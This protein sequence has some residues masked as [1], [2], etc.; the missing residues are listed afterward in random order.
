[1]KDCFIISKSLVSLSIPWSGVII[2]RESKDTFIWFRKNGSFETNR[3][4]DFTR[5]FGILGGFRGRYFE[6]LGDFYCEF[7]FPVFYR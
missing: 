2:A 6:V 1:M 3:Y 7:E 4:P 5:Y